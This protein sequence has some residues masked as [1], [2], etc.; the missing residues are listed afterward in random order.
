ML[1][2]PHIFKLVSFANNRTIKSKNDELLYTKDG[3][4][5][6]TFITYCHSYP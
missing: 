3:Y 4:V 2:G 6:C 1:R 5:N